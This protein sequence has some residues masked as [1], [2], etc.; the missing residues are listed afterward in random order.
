[1]ILAKGKDLIGVAIYKFDDT[2]MSGVRS[3]ISK[4]AEGKAQLEIVDSQ[5][6]QPTQNDKVDSIH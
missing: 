2:F 3:A 5:N 4:A 1:M 6:S